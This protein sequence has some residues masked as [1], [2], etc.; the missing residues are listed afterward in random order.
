MLKML[1]RIWNE[2][3]RGEN[4]DAYLTIGAALVLSILSLLG[5]TSTD[6]LPAITLAALAFIA[7][8]SLV[9]RHQVEALKG[10]LASG[11]DFFV[12]EFDQQTIKNDLMSADEI[13][14]YGAS[15]DDVVK[16]YYSLFEKKL[17]DK[18]AI[19]V[20]VLDPNSPLIL[21]LSEMR[22]YV[23]PN[24]QRAATKALTAL[25]DFCA[26]RLIAP[27]KLQLRTLKYPITH[28]MIAINPQKADGKLYI[29]N[30][31]YGTPGGSLP[32]FVLSAQNGQWFNLYKQE[33][34]NLWSAGQEWNCG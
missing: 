20:M 14:L 33:A 19:R 29:S 8:S 28:R 10:N 4:I 16:D 34:E 5:I 23:N 26:L 13:W 25:S 9:I 11:R 22:A 30:Y 21:E 12:S 18:K 15:L 3:R 7:I 31:P 32:K 24:A 6:K 17:R 1:Q 2:V 27:A